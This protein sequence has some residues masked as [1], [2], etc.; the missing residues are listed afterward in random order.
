MEK[1]G[2]LSKGQILALRDD[3]LVS[4][5][6]RTAV[7][8]VNAKALRGR[9]PVRLLKQEEWIRDEILVRMR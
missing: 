6:K 7:D 2:Y 9:A 1:S 4:A 8:L 3:E 5:F